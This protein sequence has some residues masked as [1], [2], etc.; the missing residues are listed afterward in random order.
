MAI[1]WLTG[2]TLLDQDMAEQRIRNWRQLRDWN[3]GFII[4]ASISVGIMGYLAWPVWGL[5]K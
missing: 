1:L 5:V 3:W 4:G 2:R